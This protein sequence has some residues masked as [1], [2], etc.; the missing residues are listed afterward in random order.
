[1]QVSLDIFLNLLIINQLLKD[2]T[3]TS[4]CLSHVNTDDILGESLSDSE[5][6]NFDSDYKK[7]KEL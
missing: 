5:D 2:M 1:M 4:K 3:L 7:V 6:G